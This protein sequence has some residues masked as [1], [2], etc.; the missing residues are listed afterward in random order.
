[1]AKSVGSDAIAVVVNKIKAN[2]SAI[3]T[4][5][6]ALQTLNGTGAGSVSKAVTDGIASVVD[7]APATFDTL[8][9]I[10]DWIESDTTGAAAMA[11]QL[12]SVQSSITTINQSITNLQAGGGVEFF[13]TA[14]ADAWFA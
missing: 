3:E 2:T 1:M 10:A 12:T 4:N 7:G 13:T 11:N 9:E 5:R 8:K 14:E 6:Q